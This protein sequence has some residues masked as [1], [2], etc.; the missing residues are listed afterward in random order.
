M[1][2]GPAFR[3]EGRTVG[4][5][6]A[7]VVTRDMAVREPVEGAGQPGLAVVHRSEPQR[8]V[9]GDEAVIQPVLRTV[10]LDRQDEVEC[11]GF[12]VEAIEAAAHAADQR[13]I[14]GG[15]GEAGL[16]RSVPRSPGTV[17]DAD[18]VQ[19][20]PL[21]VDEPDRP[22]LRVPDRAFAQF[23]PDIPDQFGLR[24]FQLQE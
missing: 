20:P 13:A 21:D 5:A 15:Q 16:V 4:D 17:I 10:G 8:A 24:H 19:L 3:A 14:L 23:R 18:A 9:R 6:I 1:I 2:E 7:V 22:T 12:G 11:A